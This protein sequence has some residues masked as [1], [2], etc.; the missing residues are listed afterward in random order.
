MKYFLCTLVLA[1]AGPM[2]WAQVDHRLT[3]VYFDSD[4][5]RLTL[6]DKDS[7]RAFLTTLPDTI[8]LDYHLYGHTDSDHSDAYNLVL[9]RNRCEG[10]EYFLKE[11]GIADSSIFIHPFGEKYPIGTNETDI[12]KQKNRRTDLYVVFQIPAQLDSSLTDTI[13]IETALADNS[14][15]R[16]RKR[17]K[18][19]RRRTILV[20]GEP[21]P[22]EEGE[23]TLT[24][25][26]GTLI[27]MDQCD[28][29]GNRREL[30]LTELLDGENLRES[31]ITTMNTDGNPLVSAGMFRV[32]QPDSVCSTVYLP[33]QEDWMARMPFSLWNG[34]NSGTWSAAKDMTIEQVRRNGQLYNKFEVCG[35]SFI[36]LDFL[37]KDFWQQMEDQ[38]QQMMADTREEGDEED[39]FIEDPFR[40]KPIRAMFKVKGRM[41]IHEVR[42]SS[43]RPLVL[44]AMK[45]NINGSRRK[46][47]F[48]VPFPD[49]D[50][51]VFAEAQDGQGNELVMPYDFLEGLP[52]KWVRK[53]VKDRNGFER[54]VRVRKYFLTMAD[55]EPKT[56]EETVAAR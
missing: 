38:E 55:F 48:D 12:G 6:D 22:C 54:K 25:P 11:M 5:Y 36:N 20:N 14:P 56:P 19:K 51:Q 13:Q 28:Y 16:T 31:G 47:I 3:H 30:E 45:P 41:K 52:Y 42:L 1:L 4:D 26:K 18:K 37:L 34:N 15:N 10:V 44:Y 35:K 53:K 24:L 9:S 7:L 32:D 23:I 2:G 29:Y 33:I 21:T 8:E 39:E 40:R 43:D 46:V 27:E 50:P 17:R 49:A